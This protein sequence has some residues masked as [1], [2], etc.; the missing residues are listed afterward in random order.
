MEHEGI[1]NLTSLFTVPLLCAAAACVVGCGLWSRCGV[2]SD[3]PHW[4][5]FSVLDE[6]FLEYMWVTG[7]WMYALIYRQLQDCTVT[8]RRFF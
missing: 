6:N 8:C 5:T 4:P 1:V 7:N 3:R 2:R